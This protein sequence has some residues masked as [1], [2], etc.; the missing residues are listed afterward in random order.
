M[1]ALD[2]TGNA[3]QYLSNKELKRA[4]RLFTLL[5]KLGGMNRSGK[6]NSWASIPPVNFLLK[7]R[8]FD[9]FSGGLTLE[10]CERVG[11]ELWGYGV[12][13]SPA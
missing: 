1:I 5:S 13:S 10:T 11:D 6:A 3:F 9:F 12:Y 2:N 8:I 4:C 7:N